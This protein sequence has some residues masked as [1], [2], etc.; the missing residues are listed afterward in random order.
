MKKLNLKIITIGIVILTL[1]LLILK[2]SSIDQSSNIPIT[3]NNN[4]QISIENYVNKNDSLTIQNK[5]PYSKI[6][7]SNCIGNYS[8]INRITNYLYSIS[9]TFT[10]QNIVYNTLTDTLLKYKY[11]NNFNIT[12][13]SMISLYQWVVGL[14]YMSKI[15]VNNQLIYQGAFLYWNGKISTYLNNYS[16]ENTS[17][18]NKFKFK[19]LVAKVEENGGSVSVKQTSTDKFV[20]NLIESNYAHLISATWNQTSI[21]QKIILTIFIIITIY[22]YFYAIKKMIKNE[23]N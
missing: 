18:R 8:E 9:D 20:S 2:L 4:N 11:D 23:K 16:K 15:D 19:Y 12:I 6:I 17:N 14:N 22:T 13:D 7:K 3:A 5:F 10:I 1:S 21:I